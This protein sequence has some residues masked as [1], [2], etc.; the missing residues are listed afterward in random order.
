LRGHDD[1]IRIIL[2]KVSH[3]QFIAVWLSL[4]DLLC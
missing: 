1:K 3:F 4:A 2:N